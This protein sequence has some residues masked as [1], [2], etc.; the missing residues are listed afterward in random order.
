M[1]LFDTKRSGQMEIYYQKV[2]QFERVGVAE[3]EARHLA[4]KEAGRMFRKK[5]RSRN[6]QL[7]W[8]FQVDLKGQKYLFEE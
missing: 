4:L 6:E 8:H 5:K 2:K 1:K 7:I 3:A